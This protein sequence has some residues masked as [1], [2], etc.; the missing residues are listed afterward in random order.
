MLIIIIVAR[1]QA[2]IVGIGRARH[3]AGV[4]EDRNRRGPGIVRT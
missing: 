1:I 4:G 2:T 3:T